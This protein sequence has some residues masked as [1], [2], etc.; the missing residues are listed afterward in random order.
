[1]CHYYEC[2]QGCRQYIN[3]LLGRC[4]LQIARKS[5]GTEPR[6]V[7]SMVFAL[8]ILWFASRYDPFI[9]VTKWTTPTPLITR[10]G[11]NG[12]RVD[13]THCRITMDHIRGASDLDVRMP[14]REENL[15]K[16][17]VMRRLSRQGDP[18]RVS[19]DLTYLSG[20]TIRR[21]QVMQETTK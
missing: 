19:L 15:I 9:I 3:C 16:A 14:V 8:S 13:G 18:N 5:S 21:A 17:C 12:I 11:D 20:P 10:R 4:T 7:G 2:D 1:V 6:N